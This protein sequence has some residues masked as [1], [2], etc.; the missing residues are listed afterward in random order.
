MENYLATAGL[1]TGSI[2]ALGILYRVWRHIRGKKLISDCCGLKGEVGVDVRD[3]SPAVGEVKKEEGQ[4]VMALDFDAIQI[5]NHA[6][7][8]K[9]PQKRLEEKET[10][11]ELHI[12]LPRQSEV[13]GSVP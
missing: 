5:R 3:M 6:V 2:V 11:S 8:L 7:S 10:S 1:S 13:E 12:H 4:C 9:E